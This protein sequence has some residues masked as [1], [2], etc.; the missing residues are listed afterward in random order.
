VKKRPLTLAEVKGLVY[1]TW[2]R[3]L[4]MLTPDQKRLLEYLSKFVKVDDAKAA[5]EAVREIMEK[6]EL[7]EEDAVMLVNNLPE[8]KD[9]LRAF[10][11]RSYP[12]LSDEAYE[13]IL[14]IL[15]RL[16]GG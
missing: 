11:Y 8:S 5:R 12:L 2:S 4:A 7:S 15:K 10:L 1:D 6:F 9:E 3:N 13:G 14:S 16:R